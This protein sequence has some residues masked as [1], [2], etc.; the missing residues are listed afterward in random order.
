[1]SL[2]KHSEPTSKEIKDVTL[3][4]K[5]VLIEVGTEKL[6]VSQNAYAS[7]YF[8]P[9][10]VLETKELSQLRRESQTRRA[11]V[12]LKNLLSAYRLSVS[13]TRKRL[14]RRFGLDSKSVDLLLK[15]YLE[16]HVLDDLGYSQDFVESKR[17]KG[18]GPSYLRQELKRRGITPE[19]IAKVLAPSAESQA[20]QTDILA[21]LVQSYNDK[22]K[23]ETLE[24]RKQECLAFLVRRGYSPEASQA[25]IH[26]FYGSLSEEEKEDERQNRVLL[27]KA[28]AEKCYNSLR[29]SPADPSKKKETF[30]RRML[31]LGFSYGEIDDVMKKERY[32]HD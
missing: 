10:K 1:M 22:K 31:G 25:A 13:E 3:K 6:L 19:I 21:L 5:G 32:F 20:D 23:D 8:Y 7:G 11:E 14:F 26:D 24:R 12:Y 16:S 30:L 18:Y 9:G 28:K 17:E 15:P 4:K 29:S 2:S 27:L